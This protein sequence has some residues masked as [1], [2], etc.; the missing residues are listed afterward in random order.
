MFCVCYP[1]AN[2]F[3]ILI[4]PPLTIPSPRNS[5]SFVLTRRVV[6]SGVFLSLSAVRKISRAPPF[7]K[8]FA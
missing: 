5:P 4:S 7:I 3:K 8:R 6:P 2:S 1:V